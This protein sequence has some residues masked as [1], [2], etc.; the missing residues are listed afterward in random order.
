MPG[1]RH[2]FIAIA[3]LTAAHFCPA[4]TSPSQ[5]RPQTPSFTDSATKAQQI[6]RIEQSLEDAVAPGDT[7]LWNKY[8]DPKCYTIT[9]DGT[10]YFKKEF[11]ATF[12]PLPKGFSGYIRVTNPIFT[13][14][15]NAAVLHYV[16][17]EYEQV[18]GQKLHT[19]YG[20]ANTWYQTDDS[21]KMIGSQVFEIP[22]LPPAIKVPEQILKTYAGKYLML[23]TGVQPTQHMD[24]PGFDSSISTITLT[25]DTLFIQKRSGNPVPLSAE[26][27]TVF[28]RQA[29]TRG[30]KFFVKN[31]KGEMLMLERRNGN[32]L[33]WKRIK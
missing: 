33:V 23:G 20:I 24:Q 18:F 12:G 27:E 9:E 13:F 28:F 11:I 22:Q 8:L 31:E 25:N 29:D 17:D 15:G 1:R 10:G 26:T 21:W 32:D 30:R 5:P 19:T 6:L 7:S 4:Q 2:L 14:I 16:A 3:F